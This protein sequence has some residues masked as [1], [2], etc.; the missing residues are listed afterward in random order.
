MSRNT[1]RCRAVEIS[2]HWPS[3]RRRCNPCNLK[4]FEQDTARAQAILRLMRAALAVKLYQVRGSTMS[5][6]EV[7]RKRSQ[8]FETH[9]VTSLL[10]SRVHFSFCVM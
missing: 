6:T 3:V 10:L 2:F 7:R 5:F 4:R 1:V 8:A 9:Y